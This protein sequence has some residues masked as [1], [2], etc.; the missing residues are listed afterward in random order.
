[1]TRSSRWVFLAATFA[2]MPVLAQINI[3]PLEDPPELAP[4]ALVRVF[5]QACI[6]TSGRAGPA[7][8]WALG[9]GF[10]PVDPMRADEG[11]LDGKAGTV[12]VAPGTYG[13]VMLAVTE[14]QCSVWVERVSGPGL[15]QALSVHIG[16]LEGKGHKLTPIVNR[17]VERSGAWRN[18][19]QWRYRAVGA[20]QDLGL[21]A[22]TTLLEAP[23]TQVMHLAPIARTPVTAPDGTPLRVDG[24]PAS[25]R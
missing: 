5:D 20:S 15:R 13:R 25:A 21:G 16:R 11:L 6:D 7:V 2:A 12:L 18:Q 3:V 14:R 9:Q 24:L 19:A 10:E 1:M 22:V 4:E 23:G 8:D 17:S